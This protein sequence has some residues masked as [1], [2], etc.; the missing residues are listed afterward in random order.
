MKHKGNFGF[1]ISDFGFVC[2][3]LVAFTMTCSAQTI[4]EIA[5][6]ERERQKRVEAGAKVVVVTQGVPATTGAASGSTTSAP[7]APAAPS[8]APAMAKPAGPL[9]NQGRDEKYWRGAFQAAR[10]EMKRAEDKVAITE[11][12]LKDLNSQML[13]NSALYNREYRLGPQ[14]TDTQKELDTAKKDAEQAKKKVADLEDQLRRSNGL[15]GWA[16]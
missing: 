8:G 16:R 6:Q 10:A 12:K 9:D 3:F 11:L 5:R 14:I 2:L 1:R 7:T 13:L 4:A 15:P